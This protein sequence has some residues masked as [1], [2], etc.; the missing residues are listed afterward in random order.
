MRVIKHRRSE[1]VAL[2]VVGRNYHVDMGLGVVFGFVPDNNINIL[3]KQHQTPKQAVSRKTG[4]PT[5][6]QSGNL[7]LVKPHEFGGFRLAQFL[8]ID[9]FRNLLSQ[10]HTG[11]GFIRIMPPKVGKN[12][13]AAGVDGYFFVVLIAHGVLIAKQA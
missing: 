1:S 9:E 5:S 3:T 13:A 12:V 11:K 4:Q 10:S 2:I 7:R 6:Y 8:P